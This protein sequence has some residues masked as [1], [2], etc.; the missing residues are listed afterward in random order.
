MPSPASV[1]AQSQPGPQS[2][3]QPA[4]A[5]ATAEGYRAQARWCVATAGI[6]DA[7]VML[8]EARE[9]QAAAELQVNATRPATAVPAQEDS[10]AAEME[11]NAAHCVMAAP[12]QED[13]AGEPS[14]ERPAQGTSAAP[15]RRKGLKAQRWGKE[16]WA[17]MECGF[18]NFRK[19]KV[20]IGKHCP[21]TR[22]ASTS[23]LVDAAVPQD[24]AHSDS[25]WGEWTGRTPPARDA[26]GEEPDEADQIESP[27]GEVP[28]QTI[29]YSVLQGSS[30][31]S[32]KG[33]GQFQGRVPQAKG[34]SKG[35]GKH[36]SKSNLP[37]IRRGTRGRVDRP[38]RSA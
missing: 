14:L 36:K 33:K 19:R 2:S 23:E 21:G 28:I 35:R 15:A 9:A 34:S 16:D 38:S 30:K 13:R 4:S 1:T 37:P 7:E 20:C 24:E 31:G 26:P 12:G 6:M 27:E 18:V 8:R 29:H 17:C 3:R 22:N 32:S 10:A 5:P 25:P 11:L